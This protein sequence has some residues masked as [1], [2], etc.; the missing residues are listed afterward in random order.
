MRKSLLFLALAASLL[1]F[2]VPA[3]TVG[4]ARKIPPSCMTYA[5]DRARAPKTLDQK[6]GARL[7]ALEQVCLLSYSADDLRELVAAVTFTYRGNLEV[8]TGATMQDDNAPPNS[9]V[10]TT[11]GGRYQYSADPAISLIGTQPIS[12]TTNLGS[13][14][15]YNSGWIDANATGAKSIDISTEASSSGTFYVLASDDSANSLMTFGMPCNG[16]S[17]SCTNTTVN[18]SGTNYP[19]TGVYSVA[20]SSVPPP[21]NSGAIY[22]G[23]RYF[24]VVYVN[25]ATAQTSFE[26]QVTAGQMARNVNAT[27]INN[28]SFGITG[29]VNSNFAQVGGSNVPANGMPSLPEADSQATA[30]PGIFADNPSNATCNSSTAGARCTITI[31]STSPTELISAPG[32]GLYTYMTSLA[33]Y[34]SSG[35]ATG[36]TIGQGTGGNC[37][38]TFNPLVTIPAG[39]TG[40]IPAEVISPWNPLFTYSAN[41]RMCAEL[42]AAVTSVTLSASFAAP[43][44]AP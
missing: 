18:L 27:L 10:I 23:H 39:T 2:A 19:N 40:A 35:T 1:G 44:I 38:T 42:T 16:V 3:A 41:V 8:P 29:T 30:R 21:T 37:T 36:V 43:A 17:T 13:S 20:G 6:T 15:T 28:P 31:S 34:N 4:A 14:A 33:I 12:T 26:L 25:G 32:A 11:T 9:F 5:I 24:E 7:F 22:L